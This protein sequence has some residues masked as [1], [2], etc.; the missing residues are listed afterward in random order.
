MEVKNTTG[1]YFPIKAEIKVEKAVPEEQRLSVPETAER[2]PKEKVV[3]KA[4]EMNEF[5]KPFYISLKFQLHEK[6]DEYYV[7]VI[8][9]QTDEVL[10]EIPNKKFLDM[11][12]SLA[13]IAGLL[14]DKKL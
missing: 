9:T 2:I 7:Q 6:L 8:D 3:A 5:L 13:E 12:A 1:I 14:I 11:Y 4:N 10:K